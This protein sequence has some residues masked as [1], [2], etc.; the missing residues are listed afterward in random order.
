MAPGKFQEVTALDRNDNPVSMGF[1]P[2]W[3]PASLLDRI[4]QKDT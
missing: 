2:T 4:K 3:R 1:I